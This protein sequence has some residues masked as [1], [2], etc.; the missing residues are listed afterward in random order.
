MFKHRG[1]FKDHLV[2]VAYPLHGLDVMRDREE[3]IRLGVAEYCFAQAEAKKSYNL[4]FFN[5]EREDAFYCSQ[6]AY[7]AYLSQGINL[8]TGQ[9]VPNL[10]GTDNIIFP[11]EIWQGWYHQ[12]VK[13]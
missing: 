1:V 2:G 5:P 3:Q 12:A 8:N 9:G 6:L 7:K 4:N 11:Q 10:P 13:E